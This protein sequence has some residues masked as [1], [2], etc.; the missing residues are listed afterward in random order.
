MT[1]LQQTSDKVLKTI[2]SDNNTINTK[3]YTEFDAL[4]ELKSAIEFLLKERKNKFA[5][6]G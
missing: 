5:Y 4:K 6:L 3:E 1:T 2:Y